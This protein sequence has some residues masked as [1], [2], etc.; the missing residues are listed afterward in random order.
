M[1]TIFFD[2][3]PQ[4]PFSFQTTLDNSVYNVTIPWNLAQ[5]WYITIT[6]QTDAH[7]LTLPLIGS[8]LDFDISLTGGYFTSKIVF[9][10]A[11]QTFE[12]SP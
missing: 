10:E 11:T 2:P 6:D 12:I 7:I 1:Q 9:R 3:T 5:R 4:A 8:P